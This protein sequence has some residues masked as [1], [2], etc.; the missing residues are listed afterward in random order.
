MANPAKGVKKVIVRIG[1]D[2]KS[3]F[4]TVFRPLPFTP[5]EPHFSV[6]QF[7]QLLSD[8]KARILHVLRAQKPKSLYALAKMLDRDFKA[9]RQDIKLL[10]KFGLIRLV[11]EF[12]KKTR[13]RRLRPVLDINTL[14]VRVE[15]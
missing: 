7:R 12:D 8:E 11:S 14:Y 13:K 1:G 10:E 5:P 4:T 9:V 15:V 2:E 6:K 3:F